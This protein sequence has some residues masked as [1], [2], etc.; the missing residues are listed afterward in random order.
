MALFTDRSNWTPEIDIKIDT[1]Q[2]TFEIPKDLLSTSRCILFKRYVQN[3]GNKDD[4]N[5]S[6]IDKGGSPPKPGRS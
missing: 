1:K 5:V 3:I 4:F 2:L 6:W